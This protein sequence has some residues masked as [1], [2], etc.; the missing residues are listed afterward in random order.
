MYIPRGYAHGF[1][2]LEDDTELE[3][4]TDNKYCFETAKSIK[5][6]SLGIDWTVG[7]RVV[8]RQDL[9]SNKNRYAPML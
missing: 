7:G 5:W 9:L 1:V 6:D 3:Y 4:L 8:I 2:T